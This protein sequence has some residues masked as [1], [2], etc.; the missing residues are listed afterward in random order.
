MNI[1][2]YT[3]A[4]QNLASLLN[5]VLTDG[6]AQIKRRDGQV[7][8]IKLQP[9]TKSPFDVKGIDLNISTPEILEFVS[10]GRRKFEF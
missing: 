2:T 6:V 7:F 3:E 1:Y 4:R 10:E 8:I 5:K 9:R